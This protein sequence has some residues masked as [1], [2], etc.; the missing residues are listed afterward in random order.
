LAGGKEA[1]AAIIEKI[2]DTGGPV[3]ILHYKQAESCQL[4]VKGFR[5]AIEQ[6][7]EKAAA[8]IEIVAELE[9]GGKTDAGKKAAADA[10]QANPNLKAIFAINDPSAIGAVAAVESAGRGGKVVIVGFD[11]EKQGK[12]AIKKGQIYADPIQFPD[13]MGV[14]IIDAFIRYSK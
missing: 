6:H 5:E 4:R 1:A 8:K 14:G 2:G 12:E 7:N 3:A 9:G 13:K 10:I 11:G